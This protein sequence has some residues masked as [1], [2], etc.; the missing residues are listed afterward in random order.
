M[1]VTRVSGDTWRKVLPGCGTDS[2]Y[3]WFHELFHVIQCAA[4]QHVL[5][6]S[7]VTF[8]I[9]HPLFHCPMVS[10]ASIHCWQPWLKCAGQATP[11]TACC[12]VCR[13]AQDHR[14]W[15]WLRIVILCHTLSTHPDLGKPSRHGMSYRLSYLS[16]CFPSFS[17]LWTPVKY[18]ILSGFATFCFAEVISALALCSLAAVGLSIIASI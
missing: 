13:V 18:Q 11:Y 15:N 7:F 1:P 9:F 3:V 6:F 4:L 10:E 5:S 17:V 14:A 16:L 12:V 2:S 8:I